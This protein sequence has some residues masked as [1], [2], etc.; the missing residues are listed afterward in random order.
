[1]SDLNIFTS[2]F[3]AVS[4]AS[5]RI[6]TWKAN[7]KGFFIPAL[8]ITSAFRTF[9]TFAFLIGIFRSPRTLIK[10]SKLPS[11]SAFSMI[12]SFSVS[13]STSS[14]SLFMSLLA[15]SKSF[16]S[17]T[18]LT[19]EP[20]ITFSR[21]GADIFTPVAADT[22]STCLNIFST[23]ISFSGSGLRSAFTFVV[24]IFRPPITSVS[25]LFITPS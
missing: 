8:S 2:W 5:G 22:C 20:A 24:T 11:V 10:P 1:M 19:G 13:I 3:F 23:L 6:S 25:P 9:P 21:F 4:R 14:I 16:S 18:N 12:P 17:V 7:T 15:F